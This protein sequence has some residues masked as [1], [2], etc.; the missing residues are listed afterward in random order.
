MDV[1]EKA[2]DGKSN[3]VLFSGIAG[4]SMQQVVLCS[5]W[6]ALEVLPN[7]STH[8]EEHVIVVYPSTGKPSALKGACSVW[9]GGK[10]VSSYLS[11]F[12][13]KIAHSSVKPLHKR[14]HEV[15]KNEWNGNKCCMNYTK[16]TEEQ[17]F[18]WTQTLQTRQMVR[19][20]VRYELFSSGS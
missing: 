14:L 7:P 20:Q 8:T 10:S 4:D 6:C 16:Y 13:T 5:D 9:T 11:V 17:A 12:L 18:T 2:N 1:P 3:R 19:K 15:G